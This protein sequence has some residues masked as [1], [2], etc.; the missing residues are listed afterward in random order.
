[1]AFHGIDL[2]TDSFVDARLAAEEGLGEPIQ[3]AKYYLHGES[4]QAF[5]DSLSPSDYIVVEACAN[6][7]WF[8]DQIKDLVKRCYILD[9]NKFKAGVNKTDKI[10][11]AKLVRRLAYY[12]IARG[13]KEDFP[14]VYVP[15]KEVRELRG[16]FSTYQLLKK[17]RTQLLNRISSIL[18][19]NGISLAKKEV[20]RSGFQ[21]KL[22][23]MP[24]GKVWLL[25]IEVLFKQAETVAGEIEGIRQAIYELGARIFQEEI[26]L[27]LSI[28]GFSPLTAIALM[29]D[30]VDIN[31]F[32]SVKKFCAY[33]RTAPRVK[34]SNESIWIGPTNR[35][36]RS[37]TCTLMTQSVE[38]FAEAGEHLRTFYAR[39]KQGK[40]PGVY[41]MAMVRKILVCAYYMLKRK[42]RFRWA[43]KALYREKV[44]EFRRT[45]VK[46]KGNLHSPEAA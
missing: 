22:A 36:A 8:H 39:V 12:V 15:P 38:H 4:F 43:D 3:K 11:A 45:T 25:Q 14:L 24:L 7:F 30:V 23:D 35:Y 34:S 2:H 29:A 6:A 9:A 44:Q 46:A 26:E 40:K 42:Q 10:D 32:P 41:R 37:L 17:T 31:R 19:E 28:R 5:K 27:L 18:K 13:D 1:M 21:T 20:I 33:L 16:L